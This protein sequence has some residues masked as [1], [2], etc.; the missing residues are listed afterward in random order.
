MGGAES[1]AG[2]GIELSTE[3]IVGRL[4]HEQVAG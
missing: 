4:P 1:G 3:W 2:G